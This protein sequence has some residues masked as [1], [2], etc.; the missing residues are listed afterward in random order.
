MTPQRAITEAI[1]ARNQ[2]GTYFF[3]DP[4]LRA[5]AERKPTVTIEGIAAKLRWLADQLNIAD[6]D[7]LA[8]ECP[9]AIQPPRCQALHALPDFAALATV[10][11]DCAE[12]VDLLNSRA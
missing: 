5:L 4:E 9:L 2:D 6:A 10:A 7:M 12:Q 8:R 11:Q 1:K 3:T